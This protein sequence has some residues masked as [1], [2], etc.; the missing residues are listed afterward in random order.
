MLSRAILV[1]SGLARDLIWRTFETFQNLRYKRLK[2]PI[3]IS[4]EEKIEG[5]WNLCVIK[6]SLFQYSGIS[7]GINVNRNFYEAA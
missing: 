6:N 3:E 5:I 7:Y 1:F 4:L 2:L